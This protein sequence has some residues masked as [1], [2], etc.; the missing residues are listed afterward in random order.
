[1]SLT[2]IRSLIAVSAVLSALSLPLAVA[3]QDWALGGFDPVA[4]V[5]RDAAIPGQG[6]IS[7]TWRGKQYHFA[8]EENRALFEANPRAY[9]PGFDGFCVVAL[10]E[11]RSEPGDPQQFVTIGQRVYLVGSVARKQALMEHPRE[12]LMKAK[13][14]WVKLGM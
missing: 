12:L 3:A 8:S 13:D 7:T 1:M 14:M 5:T 2:R 10:S 4:Y 6:D 11:G 9:T